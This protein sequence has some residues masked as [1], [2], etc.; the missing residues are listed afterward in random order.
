MESIKKRIRKDFQPL[1]IAVSLKIMTPNSPASQVYNSENGEYEP[2]RGVTPLVILPEVIANCTDGSWNTPYANE[3]LSEMKWYINGKEA[4][5]VASWNGKYSID[6]VGDTRGAITISRNVA[7]GES[8]ELY[9][10]GLI[11]DTRLGVN[12]PVKT[13]SIMLTTVDKSEDEYSLSIG[14]DQ[15]IRYNP[16]EDAL[17]LYDYKV[18]NGLTTASTSARN[19]ALNENAYE[20]SISV[21]VH[22]GD[23]LLSSGYTLNLYSIGSG[24]VLTQLTTAK[25]EIITLT[26][27]KITMDLRLIEKGDFLLVVNVGGKEKARKQFSINR[28]YPKFD[29][30]PASGV[31]INPGETTHY[32]KVMVH[33]NGNIVPVPAPILK[34]VWFTD[35]DNLTGVQHNEGTETVITL[36]R[37]GIGNTYLDDWLDIYVEAEQK[38]IFKV[39]TDA[40][41]TEYTDKSGNVYIN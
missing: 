11:A 20:R 6:T 27:T 17:L 37:T 4:S 18:A 8:F 22:K 29:V 16:F 32:N 5:T 36:S 40:S 19:A 21:S 3:L 39:M 31:S 24:G 2:D 41:G 9:F 26:S 10:E 28:V 23:T 34:M 12:I 1:T 14:D 38:P 35:T 15:I 25:H 30:E 7:P 33:Y 13:D